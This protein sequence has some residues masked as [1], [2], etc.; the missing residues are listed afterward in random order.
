LGLCFVSVMS[1][2]C[3]VEQ[4]KPDTPPKP[5]LSKTM[6]VQQLA[7]QLQMRVD[8]CGR[9]LAQLSNSRNSVVI[10]SDPNGR[11]LVNGLLLE[12]DERITSAGSTIILPASLERQIRRNLK[13]NHVAPSNTGNNAV[14]KSK[15]KPR[16]P[17]VVLDPGHGGKDRGAASSA[18]HLEKNIV[19]NVTRMVAQKLRDN[20]VRVVMTRTKDV[21]VSLDRRVNIAN[22]ARCAIFVSIHADAAPSRTA[23][24]F[25][26]YVPRREKTNSASHRAGKLAEQNLTGFSRNRGVRKH[27]SKNLRVLEKTRC[28]AMLIELG[29]LS[30]R[31]EAAR[32]G[33]YH[34]Q[35]RLANSVASAIL[36]YLQ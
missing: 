16:G 13:P 35:R 34:I 30:N 36:R 20:N 11:V 33:T 26:V 23:R 18:G 12:T 14:P 15:N 28:P 17:I 25:T 32:L 1:S 21:Y 7:T 6:S 3:I 22:S 9:H 31:S 29:Y 4:T 10:I 2:G 24:G 19:L 5:V 8:K 27:P